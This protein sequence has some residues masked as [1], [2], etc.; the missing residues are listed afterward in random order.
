MPENR[1]AKTEFALPPPAS[2]TISNL[3]HLVAMDIGKSGDEKARLRI[4]FRSRMVLRLSVV[5]DGI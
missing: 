4:S 2:T 3:R 1:V 5:S